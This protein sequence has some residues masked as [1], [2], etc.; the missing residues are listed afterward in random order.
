MNLQTP[1]DLRRFRARAQDEAVVK[2]MEAAKFIA[3]QALIFLTAAITYWLA[4]RYPL[5]SSTAR[6][7]VF[8]LFGSAL[9]LFVWTA[10]ATKILK[11]RPVLLAAAGAILFALGAIAFGLANPH[12]PY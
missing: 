6:I 9:L 5:V 10:I 8:V 12:R 11:R 4:I 3:G 2:P 1:E 7:A